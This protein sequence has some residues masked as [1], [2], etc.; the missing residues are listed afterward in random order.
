MQS[1]CYFFPFETWGMWELS[2]LFKAHDNEW[3]SQNLNPGLS[4]SEVHDYYQHSEFVYAHFPPESSRVLAALI[5][6]HFNSHNTRKYTD[7][8]NQIERAQFSPT[9][10]MNKTRDLSD[11][12]ALYLSALSMLSFEASPLLAL[13]TV[14]DVGGEIDLSIGNLWF[15]DMRHKRFFFWLPQQR[16]PGKTLSSSLWFT[17]SSPDQFLCPRDKTPKWV[18]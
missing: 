13:S 18:P 10:W 16:D 5:E 15:S 6:A 8:C 12:R 4:D 1:K 7:K 11:I 3:K 2:N 14:M 9:S 17:W